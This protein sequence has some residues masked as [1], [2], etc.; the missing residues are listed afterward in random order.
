MAAMV[1]MALKRISASTKPRSPAFQAGF[2][3]IEIMLVLV[4]IGVMVGLVAISLGANPA[5]QVDREGKRLLA[6]LTEASEEAVSQGWE[7]A[8]AISGD[9]EGEGTEYQLMLLD[10]DEQA[11]R[12]P[13][14]GT[15]KKTLWSRFAADEDIRFELELEGQQLSAQQLDSL[16]RVRSLDTAESL[17]PSILMLSSGEITPF[18]LTLSY[19]DTEYRV[20]LSS[21]GVSGVFL[22]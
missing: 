8:L 20:R 18:I 12:V 2:T 6:L 21:D 19:R 15:T 14:Q 16:A 7:I 13:E 11:W 17:R 4:I 9:G 22:Q 3:L 1:A 5:S 10:V